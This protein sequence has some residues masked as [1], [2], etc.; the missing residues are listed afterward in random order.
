VVDEHAAADGGAGMDLDAGEVRP[1]CEMKR[2]ATSGRR[3]SSLGPAMQDHRM[4]AGI[5]GQHLPAVAGGGVA[6]TDA[7]DVFSSRLNMVVFLER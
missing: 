7:G 6:L 2:P 1:K 5:T 3:S 4:Q